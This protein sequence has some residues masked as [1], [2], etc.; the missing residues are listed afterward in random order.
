[1]YWV[2]SVIFVTRR[3]GK[4]GVW[5]ERCRAKQAAI[6]SVATGFVG[7]WGFPWGPIYTTR[8]LYLNAIGGKQDKGENAALLRMVGF[9]LYEGAKP[10]AALTAIE[11]SIKLEKHEATSQF[12][13]MLRSMGDTHP[14]RGFK[15]LKIVT[16]LPSLAMVSLLMLA[17]FYY[18]NQ[19]TGYAERYSGTS[20]SAPASAVVP[21]P[22]NT[23]A[24]DK[25]NSLVEQLAVE[26]HANA[27]PA[28]TRQEGTNTIHDYQLDRAKYQPSSFYNISSEIRPFLN[29]QAA[30]SDGFVT[31]AY[32]NAEMMGL[33]VAILNGF[34]AGTDV[35]NLVDQVRTLG[36]DE[37]TSD[38]LH[39]NGGFANL[40]SLETTLD[41][42]VKQPHTGVTH[43]QAEEMLKSFDNEIQEAE[44]RIKEARAEGD[45]ADE[46]TWVEAHNHSV[47]LY[48]NLLTSEKHR[49]VLYQKADVGFNKCL[50]SKILLS[51][52]QEVN[53]TNDAAQI[54]ALPEN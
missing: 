54:E 43:Q 10:Q 31:S 51:K 41:K 3:G 32:F 28:G 49:Q 8:A 36:R 46:H 22:S 30:N 2:V 13:D 42:M 48:N 9:Q 11:E 39:A 47:T 1:M 53:I 29:D 20:G 52:F 15:K 45:T 5:C 7:W 6:W 38:W 34:D 14:P 27:T 26:V 33:S 17:I 37:R 23:S 4:G 50:D 19:P 24:R 18:A 21:T 35:S 44:A 25:V 40:L 12:A 16:A